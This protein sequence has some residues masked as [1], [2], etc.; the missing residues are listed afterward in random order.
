MAKLKKRRSFYLKLISKK[1]KFIILCVCCLSVIFVTALILRHK[2]FDIAFA[3]EENKKYIKWVDF[4]VTYPAMLKAMDVDIKSYNPDEGK[5][6]DWIE[7]LSY[8]AAKY[9]G[10]FKKYKESD[11]DD[12]IKKVDEGNKI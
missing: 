9:G 2:N 6:Y 5:K 10:D 11:I 12:L 7:I 4:S 8:L 3:K 1:I